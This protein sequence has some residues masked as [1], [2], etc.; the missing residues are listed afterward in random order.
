MD[1]RTRRDDATRYDSNTMSDRSP[2]DERTTA[3][4]PTSPRDK[5]ID[6][7]QLTHGELAE[8]WPIG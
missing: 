6:M 1:R 2:R 4:E 7:K 3:D 5:A 8:R